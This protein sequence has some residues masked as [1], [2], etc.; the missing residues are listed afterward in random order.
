M[1]TLDR[2]SSFFIRCIKPNDDQKAGVLN[3]F[4][5]QQ[6]LE[7]GGMIGVL[8]LMKKGYPC[9]IP[10]KELWNRYSDVL[11]TVMRRQINSKDFTEVILMYLKTKP[12][13]F[14]IGHTRAF[15]RF[16]ALQVRS[17]DGRHTVVKFEMDKVW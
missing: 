17:H 6:Q 11:P 5:V 4:R 3:K 10:F 8:E 15:F 13:D 9:R 1:Y 2:T 7:T 14:R 16:G 12:D